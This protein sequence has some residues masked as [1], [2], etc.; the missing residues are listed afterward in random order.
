[1]SA[2][3]LSPLAAV[4][5]AR[6]PDA[7]VPF[8]QLARF[9]APLVKAH[10]PERI[11]TELQGYLAQTEPRYLNLAKFAATFGTWAQKPQEKPRPAHY[12]TADE[13]DRDAGI[14]VGAR[15]LVK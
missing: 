4:W 2:T 12:R 8:K 11:C 1:M 6:Y 15:G 3:W 9:L 14:P 7:P 5:Y 10:S 13:C